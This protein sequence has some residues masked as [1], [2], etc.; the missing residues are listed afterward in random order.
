M[1]WAV[2][3]GSFLTPHHLPLSLF[4]NPGGKPSTLPCV[5]LP[6]FKNTYL[7]LL[8]NGAQSLTSWQD[9]SQLGC[10]CYESRGF[11]LFY[12]LLYSQCLWCRVPS[13]ISLNEQVWKVCLLLWISISSV[14]QGSITMPCPLVPFIIQDPPS[15]TWPY[16]FDPNVFP[17]LQFSAS[18]HIPPYCSQSS[19]S[20][21]PHSHALPQH[22]FALA[23][24]LPHHLLGFLLESGKKKSEV[25]PG[26]EESSL[27][28]RNMLISIVAWKRWC[29]NNDKK[30]L[31]LG[32]HAEE[33]GGDEGSVTY[34][35]TH[36]F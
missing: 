1:S 16:F 23:A 18:S 6:L 5:C 31:T 15:I 32:L 25:D 21:F 7:S 30:L 9:P 14:P 29:K 24:V 28:H 2:A 35:R 17:I 8:A 13:Q 22:H 26:Q 33:R 12:P 3:G 36:V 20:W 4:N 10:T 34:S 27:S 11:A 19:S